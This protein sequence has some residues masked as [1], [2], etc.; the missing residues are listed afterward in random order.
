MEYDPVK[1]A[2]MAVFIRAYQNEH[3]KYPVLPDPIAGTLF[4][5]V[6]FSEMQKFAAENALQFQSRGEKE[7]VQEET[8][9]QAFADNFLPPVQITGMKY[10]ENVLKSA[11]LD[12]VKQYVI[13][14]AGYDTFAWREPSMTMSLAVYEVDHPEILEDKKKRLKQAKLA[15]P[16]NLCFVP[17][18]SQFAFAERLNA[19]GFDK[20]R[21]TLFRWMGESV[22]LTDSQIR[23]VLGEISG[24]AAPGSVLLMDYA[25]ETFF[26]TEEPRVKN[27]LNF[28]RSAGRPMQF[29]CDSVYMS[30]LL[31][32]F[33]FQLCEE[34]L[35]EDADFQYLRHTAATGFP[36]IRFVQARAGNF[37]KIG[38]KE[39]ILRTSLRLFASRGYDAVSVRDIARDLGMSQSALYRH[40]RN[41]QD[42]L[43]SILQRMEERKAEI[44]GDSVRTA[45]EL[46]R[47]ALSLFRYWTQD[48]FAAA[49]R[50]FLTVEQY[51]SPAM[52][53]L[54][55]QYIS[56]GVLEHCTTIFRE[57]GMEDAQQRAIRFYAPV[58]LL[59]NRYDAAPD[60]ADVYRMLEEYLAHLE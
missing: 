11:I 23:Y 42:I 49:F 37:Q 50:K 34:L 27:M 33:G 1:R 15:V 26:R 46:Q 28:S 39:K 20:S 53:A 60:K 7:D 54:Y 13:M 58:Y 48:S 21:K 14:E 12:G 19:A 52:A 29:C 32:E 36:H 44:A 6:E 2:A 40:Y 59:M 51:R 5:C 4:S 24:L 31:E 18:Q 43:D 22:F 16:E 25:D 56:G 47:Y 9:V 38:T 45:E 57:M 30:K 3:E 35:P 10:C 17:V 55:Q 41:K 8:A